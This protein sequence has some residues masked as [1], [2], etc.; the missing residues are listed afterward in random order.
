MKKRLTTLAA[1]SLAALPS[2]AHAHHQHD[3]SFMGTVV[4]YLT[5]DEHVGF[6]VL[7]VVIGGFALAKILPRFQAAR[8]GA[9]DRG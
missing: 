4:H 3:S 6:F 5:T 9:K 1:L 2:V 7:A 8:V